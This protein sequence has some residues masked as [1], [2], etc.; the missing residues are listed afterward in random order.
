MPFILPRAAP[1]EQHDPLTLDGTATVLL[2]YVM[3]SVERSE[4]QSPTPQ[5][6]GC[7]CVNSHPSDNQKD[8]DDASMD[9]I[10]Q[11]SMISSPTPSI[12]VPFDAHVLPG[13]GRR[14]WAI[15]PLLC[16]TDEASISSILSS[17]LNQ[18][19]VWG[20][21]D[22]VVGVVFS[23][24]GTVEQVLLGWL[25]F[26][27]TDECNL[28]HNHSCLDAYI[29][30]LGTQSI[31]N[32]ARPDIYCV[33]RIVRFNGSSNCVF[34]CPIHLWLQRAFSR[35]HEKPQVHTLHWRS[36]HITIDDQKPNGKQ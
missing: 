34:L 31:V 19:R 35:H 14:F 13:R 9:Y 16:V 6:D 30:L 10:E 26:E 2:S 11:S 15:L 1:S 25:D 17:V 32:T 20:I 27:I 29:N 24:V 18:Q 33:T 7:Q 21:F 23:E 4:S 5:N 28:V 36:D 12:D 22:P 8:D 3:D